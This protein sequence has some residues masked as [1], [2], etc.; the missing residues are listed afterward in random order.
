M[1]RDAEQYLLDWSGRVSRSPLLIRGARQVG[2]TFLI[3]R[4][5]AV[6][7]E[8]TLVV[9]FELQPQCGDCFLSLEPS[10]II[11]HLQILMG[12]AMTPGKTL[13]FLDEIQLCP[14]AI[15][16]LRYFKE[17]MPELAV[18]GAGSLLEFTLND[19]DFRMPVGRVEFLYLYPLSFKEFLRALGEEMFVSW[20]ESVTPEEIVPNALHEK[21]LSL[22]RDYCQIGGMPEAVAYYK[23]HRTDILT[24]QNIQ[25][26]L[27]QGYRLDF[28]KYAKTQLQH[29]YLQKV[30]DQLPQHI[31]S[32][33][34]YSKF[35]PE[36]PSR[37]IKHALKMLELAGL[38]T[39]IRGAS[40]AGIPLSAHI[41]E[42]KL[43]LTFIDSGLYLRSLHL[44]PIHLQ[45]QNIELIN[46]GT[47][48]EQFVAQQLQVS[49]PLFE[50]APLYFWARDQQGS[51]AEVDYLIQIHDQVIPIEVKA[52]ASKWLKS[53]R[54]FQNTYKSP[55]G[56]R[57]SA[58]PLR[59]EELDLLSIPFYLSSEIK[60]LGKVRA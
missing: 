29:A 40:G 26:K 32:Q 22:V 56:I 16:A 4:F 44:D 34:R 60:R 52:S 53:L 6:H 54:L 55:Y 35:D 5:G 31:A 57:I 49:G 19:Q 8:N 27:L 25:S 41:N 33:V 13:L 38:C 21:G 43:K 42:K 1:F 45:Q 2:K 24:L 58:Q 9:N 18:I 11:R 46:K 39:S 48:S 30:F 12:Q 3:E 14:N 23:D 28:G 36:A 10:E 50:P 17:K 47:L 7:F 59:W 51:E 37:D 20:I 15:L